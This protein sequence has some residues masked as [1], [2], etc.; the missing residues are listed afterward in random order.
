MLFV[1]AVVSRSLTYLDNGVVFVGSTYGDSNLVK[2][3]TD[4]DENGSFIQVL[5]VFTNL[6][7]VIDMVVV[8][9]DRQGQGQ[10]VTCSGAYKEGSLRVIRNGIGIQ[11]HASLDLEGIK[12]IWPLKVATTEMSYD[13]TLVL[14]F[15]GQTRILT[16]TGEE[17]EE[18][19]ISGFVNSEQTLYAGNV[20][21]QQLLQVTHARVR[22]IERQSLQMVSEWQSP[23]GRNISVVACN[24][25][26]VIA[27]VG[28]DIYYLEILAGNIAQLSHTTLEHEVAC[29]DINPPSADVDRSDLVAIGLWTDISVRVHRLP[30]LEPI[31]TQQLG[32]EI[33]PRSVLLAMF[34]ETLY[35]LCALGDGSFFYFVL[36]PVKGTLSGR[37]K[38]VLG[39]QPTVLKPFYARGTFNVFTCS[40]RPAVIYSSSGKLVF[41]NV[42]LKEMSHMCPINTEAYPDSLAIANNTTLTFGTID[43][44]QKLHITTIPLGESPKYEFI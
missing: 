2:L 9:L 11:E 19:E 32:G 21:E 43:E 23:S 29:L 5:E 22:L 28:C 34:E 3:M 33:I 16:L 41:S 7:P 10:L 31:V 30:S 14:T 26:Q 4:C 38:V 15:V 35:L 6:G 18:T 17:V 37:K 12:G 36:D 8:D 40:D 20:T 13:N 39:T 27:A 42:N 44:I 1:Q 24:P 25:T